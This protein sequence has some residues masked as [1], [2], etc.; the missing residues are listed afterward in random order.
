MTRPPHSEFSIEILSQP[1]AASE[2]I[3]SAQ[4]IG[5]KDGSHV[6]ALIGREELRKLRHGTSDAPFTTAETVEAMDDPVRPL[7][8]RAMVT[9]AERRGIYGASERKFGRVMAELYPRGF[10]LDGADDFVR[11]GIIAQIVSKLCRYTNSSHRG[12]VDSIHDMGVYSFMLEAEDRRIQRL[13]PF[14]T[15][16]NPEDRK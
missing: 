10:P 5:E 7:M 15:Q 4:M 13:P 1:P 3:R 16:P 2:F 12:H 14:E 8:R 11:F 9:R 6:V